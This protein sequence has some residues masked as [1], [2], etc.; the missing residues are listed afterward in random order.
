M[1]WPM[2]TMLIV[3]ALC[4]AVWAASERIAARIPTETRR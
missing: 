1:L 2:L 3:V 4:P